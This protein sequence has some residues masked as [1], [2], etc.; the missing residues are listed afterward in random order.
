MSL[1]FLLQLLAQR[2]EEL[3]R[4]QT[5]AGKLEAVKGEF[6]AQRK[7]IT[8]PE[9]HEKLWHGELAAEFDQFRTVKIGWSYIEIYH[10]Q[11]SNRLEAIYEKIEWLKAEIIRLEQAIEAERRRMQKQY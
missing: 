4:L 7:K 1:S 9:L 6:I 11:L 10:T 3:E 2:R 5:A 8:E